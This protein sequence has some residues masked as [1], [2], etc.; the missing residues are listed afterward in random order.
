MNIRLDVR[1]RM[2][3]SGNTGKWQL[4]RLAKHTDTFA[5]GFSKKVLTDWNCMLHRIFKN[6]LLWRLLLERNYSVSNYWM[7]L[8]LLSCFIFL[9]STYHCVYIF[10]H[11][12]IVSLI[13]HNGM[14]MSTGTS[15]ALAMSPV[16][17][18]EYTNKRKKN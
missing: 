9:N 13:H 11:L 5:G 2:K 7:S 14:H 18:T 8:I 3:N 10:F 4:C 12:T 6:R 17:S 16:P 1:L 15:Y